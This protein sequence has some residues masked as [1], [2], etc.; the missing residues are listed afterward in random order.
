MTVTP[1]LA[2]Q[3]VETNCRTEKGRRLLAQALQES[4]DAKLLLRARG[5]GVTGTG[6][7]ETVREAMELSFK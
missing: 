2:L 3:I 7:L 4:E 1:E 6:L 5:Y